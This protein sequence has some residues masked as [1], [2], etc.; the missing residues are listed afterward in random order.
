MK[1]STRSD[2]QHGLQ[3]LEWLFLA[4][5]GLAFWFGGG[6]IHAVFPK[7]DRVL[8]EIEGIALA[9]LCA[10]LG[11][12]AKGVNDR[13]EAGDVDPNGPTSLDEVLRNRPAQAHPRHW[14]AY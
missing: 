8:A 9:I 10:G 14:L 12:L 5:A 4:A 2:A 11:A 1:P 7:A 6:V 3:G 13:R